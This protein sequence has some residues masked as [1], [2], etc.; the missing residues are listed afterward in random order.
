MKYLLLLWIQKKDCKWTLWTAPWV[1]LWVLGQSLIATAAQGQSAGLCPDLASK[2][3]P[4][5]GQ[6]SQ[7][8]E[9]D[10]HNNLEKSDKP[11][12]TGQKEA[13]DLAMDGL[14]NAIK[15]VGTLDRKTH[16]AEQIEA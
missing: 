15:M 10:R 12:N 8:C 16:T 4:G 14:K 3:S 7:P 9:S 6:G 13:S 1:L 11:L 5:A 2:P